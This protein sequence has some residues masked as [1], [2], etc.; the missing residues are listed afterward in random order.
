MSGIKL[1]GVVP[2]KENNQCQDG[3]R[4]RTVNEVHSFFTAACSEVFYSTA[5]NKL[6]FLFTFFLIK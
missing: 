5:I 1:S 6:S 3:S 2:L 4:G